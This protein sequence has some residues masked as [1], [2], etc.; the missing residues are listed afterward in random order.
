[1]KVLNRYFDAALEIE[2][3]RFGDD[4]GWFNVPWEFEA[5]AAIGI[6]KPFVQDNHS[7]SVDVGTIRGIHL[8][9]APYEQGKLVRVATGAVLDVIVDL[10]PGS[11]TVGEWAGIELSA[12]TGNQLWVPRGFGHGFCTREPNTHL[13]Y[14]VDNAYHPDAE[15]SLAWDDPSVGIDWGVDP[16]AVTLSEKDQQGADL[17]T[18][19]NDIR[20]AQ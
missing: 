9:L 6:D 10:R 4:R 20:G 1:M 18:I 8:Q 7:L 16:A 11:P 2:T 15:R 14:K 17:E 5:A 13:L 19:L 3:K 12:E